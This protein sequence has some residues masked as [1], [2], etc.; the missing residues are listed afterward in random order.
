MQYEELPV[1]GDD[2]WDQQPEPPTQPYDLW[3]RTNL[4]ENFPDPIT[5]LNATLWSTFFL[6][7]RMPT[8]AERSA[9][10]P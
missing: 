10:A 4:G 3:T 2:S 6:L 9:D 7:G 8:K 1:P 5:P